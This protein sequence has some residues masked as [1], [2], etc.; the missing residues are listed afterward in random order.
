MANELSSILDQ[1]PDRMTLAN[2]VSGD[3]LEAQFNPAEISEKLVPNYNRVGIMGLSHKPHQFPQTDNHAFEF[4]MGHRVY[5][6]RGNRL[7]DIHYARRFLLSLCYPRRG[8]GDIVGGAPPRCLFVWPNFISLTAVITGLD[9]KH[10]FFGRD[11]TPYHFGVK[12][13]IEETRDIR[14]FSEDV[15]ANGTQR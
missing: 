15:L 12:V 7:I 6:R 11:G 14:L 9:F 13:N 3:E 10:T 8:A 4:E 1:E 2:V 5:D